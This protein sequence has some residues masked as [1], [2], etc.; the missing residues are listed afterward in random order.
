MKF[1]INQF[2][3]TDSFGITTETFTIMQLSV[4]RAGG[5][6]ENYMFAKGSWKHSSFDKRSG[7]R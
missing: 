4:G 3:I 2:K 6:E 7:G 5:G 1:S